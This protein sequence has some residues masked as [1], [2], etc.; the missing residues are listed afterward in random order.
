MVVEQGLNV[1]KNLVDEIGIIR[2]PQHERGFLRGERAVD[3]G[4]DVSVEICVE[5]VAVLREPMSQRPVDDAGQPR[6]RH[7]RRPRGP[8][9]DRVLVNLDLHRFRAS[10]RQPEQAVRGDVVLRDERRDHLLVSQ[11]E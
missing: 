2:H 11:Q 4:D 1:V 8:R 10:S 5:E 6:Y 9:F 7:P 3:E